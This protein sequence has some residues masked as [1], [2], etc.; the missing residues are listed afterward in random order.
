MSKY[1]NSSVILTLLFTKISKQI[2]L[3]Y[4]IRINLKV[5]KPQGNH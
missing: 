4:I 5:R 3:Q 2:T 1:Y